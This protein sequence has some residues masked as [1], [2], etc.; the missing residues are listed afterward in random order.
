VNP[1]QELIHALYVA[2]FLSV[3]IEQE[4]DGGGYVVLRATVPGGLVMK[5]SVD[6]K[7]EGQS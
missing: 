7:W 6:T 3:E 2:G 5:V 1:V 4:D